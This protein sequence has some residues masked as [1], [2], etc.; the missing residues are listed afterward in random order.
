MTKEEEGGK[1]T[2][3]EVEGPSRNMHKGPMDKAKVGAGLR[4]GGGLGKVVVG[5]WR[6]LCLNNNKN[7]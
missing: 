4:G 2:G 6:Q 7:K 1:I 5:K 3:K